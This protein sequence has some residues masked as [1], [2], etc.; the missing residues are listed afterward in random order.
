QEHAAHIMRWLMMLSS[1]GSW[2]TC[3]L[4]GF[5]TF[6]HTAFTAH[7]DEAV[8]GHGRDV[9]DHGAELQTEAAM[10][11]QERI[12]GDLRAHRAIPQDEVG[13]DGEH[14]TTRR[15]LDPPDGDPM[16]T[17]ADIMRVAGE[18]PS[19]A[20]A[21]LVCELKAE[22]EEESAHAFDKRLAIAKQLK[23]SRFILKING[24]SPVFAWLF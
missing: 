23:V 12:T 22:G 14:R 10:R 15:A 9:A 16:H 1:K 20:T 19:T 17:E 3:I 18:T 7:T 13:Q 11:G 6:F 21:R 4:Q 2:S 8:K 24:D 5:S